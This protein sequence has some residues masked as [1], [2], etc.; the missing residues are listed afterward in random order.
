MT[1]NTNLIIDT[2]HLQLAATRLYRVP[3][4]QAQF[5]I[6]N[7]KEMLLRQ[8]ARIMEVTADSSRDSSLSAEDR[9]V[10]MQHM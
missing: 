4:H 10:C 6:D 5:I 3:E 2:P 8:I 1:I 7:E 9:Q